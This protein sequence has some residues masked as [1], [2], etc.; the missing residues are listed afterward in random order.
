MSADARPRARGAEDADGDSD[1]GV[2]IV[3]VVAGDVGTG[4]EGKSAAAVRGATAPRG[5]GVSVK[6]I[7][8]DTC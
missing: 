3:E 2:V 6:R 1:G 8:T 7:A 4:G 5:G